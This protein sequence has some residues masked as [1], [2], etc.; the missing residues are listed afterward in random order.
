MGV[1]GDVRWPLDPK[2]AAEL[3]IDASLHL[4]FSWFQSLALC[5]FIAANWTL[6]R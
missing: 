6:V 3:V 2:T 5:S 4:P 1:V